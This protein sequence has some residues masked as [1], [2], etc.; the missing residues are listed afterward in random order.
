MTSNRNLF[1]EGKN[2]RMVLAI[3]EKTGQGPGEA[4]DAASMRC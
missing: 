1:W 2:D 3:V 4:Y